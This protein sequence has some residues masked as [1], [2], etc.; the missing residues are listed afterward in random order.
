[1]LPEEAPVERI[2]NTIL[3]YALKAS[4]QS[5]TLDPTAKGI[6]VLFQVGGE[7]REEMKMPQYV[8]KPLLASIRKMTTQG[9]AIATSER[10]LI[11]VRL[12]DEKLPLTINFN[13]EV[14]L[15]A[16]QYGEKARFEFKS[17]TGTQITQW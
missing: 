1:M 17:P 4:A 13:L 9:D 6:L 14:E 8:H 15:E 7:Q 5:F 3:F 2:F 12:K 11:E 10:A 16:T